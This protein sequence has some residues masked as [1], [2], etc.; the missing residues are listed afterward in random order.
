L[1]SPSYL[2]QY[3][4]AVMSLQA[5]GSDNDDAIE[6]SLL[7][8]IK[9]NPD[10]A[11]SYD[12]LAGLYARHHEKLDQ[13]HIL[14]VQAVQLEPEN[15]NYRL[16]T[17][18][19]LIEEQQLPGAVGVLNAALK[20][21]KTP[22]EIA[23]VQ[24]RIDQAETY[25]ASLARAKDAEAQ[26]AAGIST[27]SVITMTR[28]GL[29]DQPEDAEAPKY[30]TEEPTGKHHNVKGMLSN[31]HCYY[32]AVITF[33]VDQGGKKVSLYR[34]NYYKIV[35]STANYTPTGDIKPC[36]EIQG[37]KASVDYAEVSDKTIAGQIVSIELSK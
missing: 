20:V 5:G 23:S 17:A 14:N 35:F 18:Q 27:H 15:L 12:T 37:M 10:F 1:G 30:P 4:F 3:Y 31:V 13:A 2:A 8:A 28:A 16:N 24:Q 11:P 34:N 7:Q 21:A 9:L 25:Q 36:T 19:V 22:E 6:A 32:P 29:G 26:M 33:D